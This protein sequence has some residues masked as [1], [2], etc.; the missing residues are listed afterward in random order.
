MCYRHEEVKLP[1]YKNVERR[2]GHAARSFRH[3]E[4][5]MAPVGAAPN[6]QIRL[7]LTGD[8]A[9]EVSESDPYPVT[10]SPGPL[11]LVP[12]PAGS[13]TSFQ[14][15]K[16]LPKPPPTTRGLQRPYLANSM[17]NRSKKGA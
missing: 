6:L 9:L 11:L 5:R 15:D 12:I 2:S 3:R 4:L 13:A 17:R 10:T 8:L 16:Q 7:P 14:N 1:A